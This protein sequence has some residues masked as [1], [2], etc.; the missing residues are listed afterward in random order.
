MDKDPNK[1]GSTGTTGFPAAPPPHK[2]PPESPGLRGT[3][4]G[5]GLP[6]ADVGVKG[7]PSPGGK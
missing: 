2:M 3:D 6:G 1:T 4:F 5:T 7:T